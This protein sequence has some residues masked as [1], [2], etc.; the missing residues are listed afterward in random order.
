LSRFLTTRA[1]RSSKSTSRIARLAIF[2]A[3]RTS[4]TRN[5]SRGQFWLG[6]VSRRRSQKAVPSKRFGCFESLE[7]ARSGPAR[8]PSTTCSTR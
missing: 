7:Q 1:S 2:T 4:S 6:P 3:S 8:R 5:R